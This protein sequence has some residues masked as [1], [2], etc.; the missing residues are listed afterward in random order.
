MAF[1]ID[2]P[3]PNEELLY[4]RVPKAKRDPQVFWVAAQ[5][6]P[7]SAVFKDKLREVSVDRAKYGS[8]TTVRN[9]KTLAVVSLSAGQSRACG[10]DALHAPVQAG[11][12]GGPNQ[13]HSIICDP[14]NE[15]LLDEEEHAARDALASVARLEWM[16]P[17]EP[18]FQ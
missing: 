7:T 6:R 4:R 8:A 3:I 13:A 1:P 16:A 12:P 2:N 18:G 11:E 14:S 10:K 9:E 17:G 15:A 5:N